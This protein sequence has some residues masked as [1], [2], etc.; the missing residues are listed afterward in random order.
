MILEPQLIDFIVCELGFGI[1]IFVE[2]FLN[3]K[4][5]YCLSILLIFCSFFSGKIIC[6]LGKLWNGD[7]GVKV[8]KV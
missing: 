7:Q 5:L 8:N 3:C 4:I 2:K 6:N 1:G